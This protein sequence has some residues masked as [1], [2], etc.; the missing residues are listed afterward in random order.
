[1]KNFG[2]QNIWCVASSGKLKGTLK[3]EIDESRPKRPYIGEHSKDKLMRHMVMC[4]ESSIKIV[5]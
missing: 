1:M 2:W 3:C 5:V 4:K